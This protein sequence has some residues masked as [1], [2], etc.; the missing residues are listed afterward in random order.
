[1]LREIADH[2]RAGGLA[3]MPTET[4]YGFSCIP[5]AGPIRRLQQLKGRGVDQ[6]FLILIPHPGAVPELAW[7]DDSRALAEA[8]WPGALTVILEDP[9][10]RFP[11][12]IRSREGGVAVR[13]SPETLVGAVL[14]AVREPLVSTSANRPGGSPA[15]SGQDALE[16]ARHLGADESFWVLDGGFL[17]PSDPSTIVDCSGPVPVVRRPGAIPLNH[18][19][20]VIPEIH[21][22]V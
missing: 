7:G 21:E 10:E 6:P 2:L 14:A 1:M 20:S 22:S 15:L 17:R 16:I 9:T 4:V 5:E 13:V 19:R 3:A 11:P 8:F 18:L 12:G